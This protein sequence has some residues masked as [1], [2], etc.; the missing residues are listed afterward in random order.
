VIDVRIHNV[1]QLAGFAKKPDL[2]YF[3]REIAGIEYVHLPILAPTEEMLKRYRAG[4][5]S[6]AAYAK[7]FTRLITSRQIEQHVSPDL[8]DGACLLCSEDKA[9]QCH[10]SLVAEYLRQAWRDIEV[11]ITHL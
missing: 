6:W 8:L 11:R 3:L 4:K 1:S 10:R 2:E 7:Q 5:G 9:E